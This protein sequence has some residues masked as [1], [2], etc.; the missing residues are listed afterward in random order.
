MRLKSA[1]SHF[2][3]GGMRR[4]FFTWKRFTF[5]EFTVDEVNEVGPVVEDVL[6]E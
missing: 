5:K 1:L 3:D 4:G 6:R 2:A